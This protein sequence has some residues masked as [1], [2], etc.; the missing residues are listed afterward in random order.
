MD[1]SKLCESE[2]PCGRMQW[3]AKSPSCKVG[4]NSPPILKKRNAANE[5]SNTVTLTTAYLNRIAFSKSGA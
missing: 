1:V 3:K 4:M 5:K 2:V